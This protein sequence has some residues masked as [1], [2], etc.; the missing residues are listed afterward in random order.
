MNYFEYAN[1]F[2]PVYAIGDFGGYGTF[3][4]S[5]LISIERLEIA[6]EVHFRMITHSVLGRQESA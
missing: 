5:L 4:L 2:F 6:G 1:T 3:A